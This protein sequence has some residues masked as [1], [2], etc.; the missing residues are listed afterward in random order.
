MADYIPDSDADFLIWLTK[1]VNYLSNWTTQLHLTTA[2]VTPLTDFPDLFRDAI[3]N[4]DG[5]QANFRGAVAARETLRDTIEGAIRPLVGRLQG[6]ASV[7]DEQRENMGITVR[8][9]T[10]SRVAAPT[11]RPV[12]T[13]DTRQRLE[14]TVIF[15]DESTPNTKAKPAGV[16]GCEIYTKVGGAP[17]ADP[18]E[19][20]YLATDTRTPYVVDFDGAQAGQIA[21]YMTRWVSTRGETGP[22]SQTVSATITA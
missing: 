19:L 17:P 21:Y 2:E 6:T 5:A 4:A 8:S 11:T 18:S 9:T 16:Q 22:W 15:V 13:I 10:R 14:H 20:K 3:T 12:V 1:F 7:T